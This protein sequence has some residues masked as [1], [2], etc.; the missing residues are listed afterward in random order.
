MEVIELEIVEPIRH[1]KQLKGMS[2][3]LKGKNLRDYTLFILG[4]NSALRISDLLNLLVVDVYDRD[5]KLIRDRI[6]LREKKTGKTKD[7]P[8]SDI[9]QRAIKLYLENFCIYTNSDF[10]FPSRKGCTHQRPISRVQAWRILNEA[11]RNVGI[12]GRIGTHTLRKSFGY[13][14]YRRGYDIVRIQKLLNHSSPGI[15][16][17]YIGITRDELDEVYLNL[18]IGV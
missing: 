7:F 6:T 3:Y 1:E 9:C 13:W 5:K 16:L 12:E 15:T 18:Q 10:L 4:I 2:N 8:L 17:A 11:A 14:A